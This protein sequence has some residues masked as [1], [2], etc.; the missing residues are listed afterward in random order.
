MIMRMTLSSMMQ[1]LGATLSIRLM[2]VVPCSFITLLNVINLIIRV[3]TLRDAM[4]QRRG[5]YT[6]LLLPECSALTGK[7]KQG[8]A[9]SRTLS[10]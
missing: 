4:K 6:C 7:Q 1:Q 3:M 9:H 2:S 5:S 10:S 8:S